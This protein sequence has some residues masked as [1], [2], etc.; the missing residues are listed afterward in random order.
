MTTAS[1]TIS[2]MVCV[3]PSVDLD[4]SL[5][6][7]PCRDCYRLPVG[8]APCG[9]FPGITGRPGLGVS[10]APIIPVLVARI[11]TVDQTVRLLPSDQNKLPFLPLKVPKI[12]KNNYPVRSVPKEQLRLPSSRA[13]NL[14]NLKILTRKSTDRCSTS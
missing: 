3:D 2:C 11:A 7:A 6:T 5:T 4:L 14:I 1:Q 13:I 12:S 9:V 8:T 10:Y